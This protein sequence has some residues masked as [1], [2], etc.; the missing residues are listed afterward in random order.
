MQGA[1]HRDPELEDKD[2]KFCS[3]IYN[4]FDTEKIDKMFSL[5]TY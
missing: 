4:P 1:Y 5:F 3:I 2:L